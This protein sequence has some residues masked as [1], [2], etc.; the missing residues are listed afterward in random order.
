MSIEALTVV[1]NHSQ[2]KG[3][4][5]LVLIGIANHHGESGAWPSVQTLAGYANLSERRVQQSITKLRELGELS[6]E[7]GGGQGGAKYKT[8]LYRV[9]VTCPEDCQGFPGHKQRVKYTSPKGEAGFVERV[10]QTTSKPIEETLEETYE[11]PLKNFKPSVS[12]ISELETKFT[13][14]DIQKEIE[15]F[16]DWTMSKGISYKDYKAAF[17]NWC[18]KA[19]EWNPKTG[20]SI[21]K[22]RQWTDSYL[23]EQEQLSKNAGPAPKCRH[24][25]NVALCRECL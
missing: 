12:F 7:V 4:D 15:S 22:Q 23:K 17:R 25:H 1:L 14:V 9:L 16:C 21:D 2:A 13:N 5:K 18:R 19:S 10:K 24:G 20:D 3:T 8:N 11:T 6:V